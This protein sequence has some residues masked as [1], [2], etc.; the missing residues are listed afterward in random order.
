MK[1]LF[2]CLFLF[3]S[4]FS[5]YGQGFSYQSVVRNSSGAPQVNT[6]VF[7][8]FSILDGSSSGASLYSETQSPNT[9]NLGWISL[10][11]GKG[12]P[13]SGMMTGINWNTPKFLMVECAESANGN[14]S[15]IGTSQLNNSLYVGPKGDKG[16]KGDKGDQGVSGPQGPAGQNGT[17]VSIVGTIPNAAALNQN[18]TGNIGDMVITEDSGSGF[19]WN[20]TMWSAVGQIQGPQGP[21]GAQG[22]QG[23]QGPEGLAGAQGQQGPQGPQGPQGL[24]GNEGPAGPAGSIGPSGPQ[25]PQGLQG[26]QGND[27]PVGPAG[28]MGPQGIEGPQGPAGAQGPQG[29]Q[30]NEGPAG[31]QG[32][33]GATGS[34]GATGPAGPTGPQ[35][36][37][38]AT[39]A[40]G[41]AGPQG[42]AGS[43]TA[44]TG[45]SIA[46]PTISAQTTSALWNANQLQGDAVLDGS[47]AQN[48]VLM[49]SPTGSNFPNT[50]QPWTLNLNPSKWTE[51]SSVIYPTS[52]KHVEPFANAS[53][54]LGSSGFR[55]RNIYLT[56]QPNIG[57]DRRIKENIKPLT[58]G[59]DAI[60]K[61]KPV[62]YNLIGNQPSEVALGL[63]AQD[64]KNIIPEIVSIENQNQRSSNDGRQTDAN[65]P[66]GMHSI[67]YGDLIPVLIKAIQELEAKV[68]KLE[69]RLAK[70]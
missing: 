3:L 58:Y 47:P 51:S 4:A 39:G 67:R 53:W 48:Q 57:S 23:P 7:L 10:E 29:P 46:S 26:L 13:V 9:D 50:W 31:P 43:Y 65:V 36:A 59:L 12:V 35:G 6:Q 54:D 11:V 15:E 68:A 5:L 44:G 66:E 18:Y 70:N 61:I 2:F 63:I 69:A 55:W 33:T 14:Y 8:R 60:M 19:V 64:V 40:T 32:A 21:T 34:T 1:K 30:G 41:P 28:S 20:G 17:G 52:G 27:G 38:G 24:Q 49:W 45:I 56:N 16:E 22:I 25:G 42:P 62:Q 37:T